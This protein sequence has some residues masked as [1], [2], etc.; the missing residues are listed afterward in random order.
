MREPVTELT[1]EAPA[2]LVKVRR[3]AATANARASPS[4]TSGLRVRAGCEVDV[5]G[6]GRISMDVAYGGMIYGLVDAESLGFGWTIR[7]P[8]TGRTRR[9]DQAS[10]SEF[11][12]PA[13]IPITRQ[14]TPS[15]RRCLPAPS[16]TPEGKRARNTVIV[17][18]G[19]HDRSPCGTG[20][21]A[22]MAV[23]HARGLLEVGETF[24]HESLIGT[25]F[26]GR[27]RGTATVGAS[28][29]C[30]RRSPVALDHRLPPV[31]AR[32]ERSVPHRLPA[33]RSVA[34]SNLT[35][36]LPAAPACA[37]SFCRR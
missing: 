6:L 8:R 21:C 24:V 32:S 1:L 20:T 7:R 31:C 12:S 16:D 17:S 22:R 37:Q 15:I 23:M 14:S 26:I 18:P 9:A 25:E 3:H 19:R 36:T 2:G 5:P 34:R 27:I 35:A 13:S 30:S 28:P 33:W 4:T 29:R 11:R 10:G